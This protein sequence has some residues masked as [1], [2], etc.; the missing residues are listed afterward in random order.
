MHA[1]HEERKAG[2]FLKTNKVNSAQIFFKK[3]LTWQITEKTIKKRIQRTYLY[4]KY[5][6]LLDE[7]LEWITQLLSLFDRIMNREASEALKPKPLF[8][9][10]LNKRETE[11]LYIINRPGPLVKIFFYVWDK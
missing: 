3:K 9:W 1:A 2:T 7:I 4:A 8:I 5:I 10:G 6:F 11:R